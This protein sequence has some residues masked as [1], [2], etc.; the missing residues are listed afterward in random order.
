ASTC[1]NVYYVSKSGHNNN[2]GLSLTQSWLTVQ[3]AANTALPGSTVYVRAGTYMETVTINVQGNSKDGYITFQNYQQEK[4]IL[5]GQNAKSTSV[6]DILNLIYIE[7]KSYL[8]IIGFELTS[9]R[10]VE[11]SGIRIVG[12]GSFIELR[13]NVI[14]NIKGGGNEGGAMAI[15]VYNKNQQQSR[16]ELII[17]NNTIY[18]C[19]PAW[20]EALT[21]NGNIEHFQVTYNLVHDVNNIAI[22][23]IGGES[24]MGSKV[25]RSGLCSNNTVY[26]VNSSYDQSA[27]GIYVDGA[28]NITIKF[29]RVYN[30][31][32]GIEIGAENKGIVASE[33]LVTN[34]YLYN[35]YK[36]G[37]AFGDVAVFRTVRNEHSFQNN[38]LENND[39]QQTGN[40]EIV[41]SYASRNKV[42]QNTIKPNSQNIV[43][44]TLPKGNEDNSFDY[45]LYHPNGK[46][47]TGD[48]LIFNWNNK[49]YDGLTQFQQETGQEKHAKV[50]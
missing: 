35:N 44:F 14:H 20:S 38:V 27:A 45:N 5:S 23:F 22:D 43:M 25:T 33:I 46:D 39:R 29:N 31:N 6:G 3:K 19:E 24:G 36:L 37:L 26:N 32:L 7:D 2:S 40:G 48:D 41:V 18:D 8:K 15:T 1:A 16:S 34:N 12:S 9:L 50:Y 11:C 28:K 47:S 42:L 4:V 10:A 21:L 13:Q 30:S 49:E 17:S